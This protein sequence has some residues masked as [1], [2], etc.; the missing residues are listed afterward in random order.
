MKPRKDFVI[1]GAIVFVVSF[2][3]IF[4]GGAL[5]FLTIAAYVVYLV[6]MVSLTAR[7]ACSK[8]RFYRILAYVLCLPLILIPRDVRN[9]IR[10]LEEDEKIP[11]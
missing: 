8:N 11:Q 10:K 9:A 1:G 3:L 7:L 5:G 2:V 6:A 4:L